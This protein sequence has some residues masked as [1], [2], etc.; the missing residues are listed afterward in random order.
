MMN[1]REHTGAGDGSSDIGEQTEIID[2][3]GGGASIH[4][5]GSDVGAYGVGTKPGMINYCSGIQ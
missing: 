4:H 3:E 1:E 2:A 5:E